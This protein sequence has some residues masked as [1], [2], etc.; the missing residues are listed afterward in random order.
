MNELTFIDDAFKDVE[1]AEK[2]AEMIA[3]GGNLPKHCYHT[4]KGE[5]DYSKPNT[6][7]ILLII[8]W[9]MSLDLSWTQALQQV[10]PIDDHMTI[11]GDLAKALIFSRGTVELWEEKAEGKM[12]AN[13]F[14]YSITASN[15]KTSIT[16][17][18][19]IWEAKQKG[20][21]P[22][23]SQLN[24]Q[25][26]AKWLQS[27]W[28][29]Y[30]ERMCMYRA[31]GF[32]ARDLWP[33]VLNG[34]IF[35]EEVS[36][37]PDMK[38]IIVQREDGDLTIENS[39]G[40]KERSDN[41]TH[42]AVEKIDQ[43]EK[44][45]TENHFSDSSKEDEKDEKHGELE[46]K[47]PT[48]ADEKNDDLGP[49]V[50]THSETW[51]R[52]TEDQLQAMG[53]EVELVA[54][55]LGIMDVIRNIDGRNTNKKIRTAIMYFQADKDGFYATYGVPAESPGPTESEDVP[56]TE[57]DQGDSEMP[58]EEQQED[59]S[60]QQGIPTIGG[61]DDEDN[62]VTEDI[63]P[64]DDTGEKEVYN[65]D[66]E[67][68]IPGRDEEGGEERKFET[69]SVIY[70]TMTNR[71]VNDDKYKVLATDIYTPGEKPEPFIKSYPDMETFCMKAT[72]VEINFF[73]STVES[74][75]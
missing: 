61:E 17:S 34:L 67:I 22:S 50:F 21:Y 14:K 10:I 40:K 26:K 30:P 18:F 55:K 15:G 9:G 70:R 68:K 2:F 3:M 42:H 43:N 47:A 71:G 38:K 19:S 46:D 7:M 12:S 51:E 27:P 39:S 66:W 33:H 74:V 41:V 31:L 75:N 5:P 52:Y 1:S 20:L 56:V 73:I 72:P 16:R 54:N 44:K 64:P 69:L 6:G 59:E 65:K 48:E 28:F 32:I 35:F 23:S 53:S 60:E 11:K 29:K 62:D 36:D 4:Q 13:S 25:H 58:P 63:T 24:G 8:S 57:P 45:A 49:N 37:Y